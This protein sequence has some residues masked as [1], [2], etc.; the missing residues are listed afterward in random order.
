VELSAPQG[1]KIAGGVAT[2]TIQNDDQ[3]TTSNS[4]EYRT[5]DDW[6]SG[7]TGEL[8]LTNRTNQAWDGWEVEFDWEH[9][10]TQFWNSK[11]V[12]HKGERYVVKN[13]SWNGRVEPGASVTFGFS[14]NPGNVVTNPRNILINGE[15][16]GGNEGSND[17][18]IE[19]SISDAAVLEP[20]AGTEVLGFTV[21]LS[22][23]VPAGQE[24]TLNFSTKPGTASAGDDFASAQG[25]LTFLPGEIEKMIEVLVKGDKVVELDE[26]FEVALSQIVNGVLVD[27]NAIGTIQNNDSEAS[28]GEIAWN[29]SSDWGTGYVAAIVIT[30]RRSE[31][32]NGWELEFDSPHEIVSIW[33][34]EIVS[35]EGTRYR[36]RSLPWNSSV[37]PS[38]AVE[39]GYQVDT[40]GPLVPTNFQLK[41]T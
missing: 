9:N 37:T 40:S 12:S 27:A 34:A 39:I 31:T 41:T 18:A 14:G 26:T 16:A 30:N 8:K 1:A 29:V 28:Q 32:W 7:F 33:G 4:A 22:K 15:S 20:D 3:A 25:T 21:T 6:G 19:V 5:V 24:T 17:D 35:R 38:G 10:L 11:L 23:A 13:E 36:L 2:V